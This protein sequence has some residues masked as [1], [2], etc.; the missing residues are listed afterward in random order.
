MEV[1]S[2]TPAAQTKSVQ[3]NDRVT[4][5]ERALKEEPRRETPPDRGRTESR[6]TD[7]DRAELSEGR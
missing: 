2:V 7:G 6:S 1:S 3:R 4:G 5:R